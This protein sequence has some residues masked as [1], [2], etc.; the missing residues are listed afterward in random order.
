MQLA[1]GHPRV[2]FEFQS[3]RAGA[4]PGMTGPGIHL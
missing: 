2:D 3:L 1:Q 4:K